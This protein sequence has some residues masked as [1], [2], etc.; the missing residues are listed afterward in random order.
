M[1]VFRSLARSFW[2]AVDFR[3]KPADA[4]GPSTGPA[5]EKQR[6]ASRLRDG[7]EY[8]QGTLRRAFTPP[9]R[10]DGFDVGARG[11][12]V[13]LTGGVKWK[14]SAPEEP[15]PAP[16][17]VPSDFVAS[18]DDLGVLL[19][20]QAQL[21]PEPPSAH[22]PGLSEPLDFFEYPAPAAQPLD[23]FEDAAPMAQQVVEQP[24]QAA[25]EQAV[26]VEQPVAAGQ[27]V[28]VEQQAP[29]EQPVAS[30]QSV[31]GQS[32]AVERPVAAEQAVATEPAAAV[33]QSVAV[34]QQRPVAI[35]QPVKQAV[36]VAPQSP[37]AQFTVELLMPVVGSARAAQPKA[38]EQ[39]S[40]LELLDTVDQLTAAPSAPGE[41]GVEQ[42][43]AAEP[44]KP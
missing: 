3:K 41:P 11:A 30:E 5:P 43:S 17:H 26:A 32:V 9:A 37:A 6:R 44:P 31:V 18:L 21:V 1:N 39:F 20:E 13:D 36:A 35:E 27:Q 2:S 23:F 25:V 34:E 8:A 22:P 16:A 33:E 42:D 24:Q 14:Y 28:V 38:V 10:G 12:P 7:F 4:E 15:A 19:A 29:I 40:T